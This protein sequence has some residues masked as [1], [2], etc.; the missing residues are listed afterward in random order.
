MLG[1]LT[2]VTHGETQRQR[3][4]HDGQLWYSSETHSHTHTYPGSLW[5]RKDVT[6][7]VIPRNNGTVT[8]TEH[9]NTLGVPESPTHVIV[10]LRPSG[11][12]TQSTGYGVQVCTHTQNALSPDLMKE[13][14]QV[15]DMVQK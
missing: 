9:S 2:N 7:H 3:E 12:L 13:A 14:S 15:R 10:S 6:H 4:S 8:M 1:K 11:S 5:K